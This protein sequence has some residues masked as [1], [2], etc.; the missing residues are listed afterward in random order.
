MKYKTLIS[1][2][3]FAILLF[4]ASGVFAQ[5]DNDPGVLPDGSLNP[6]YTSQFPESNTQIITLGTDTKD[7]DA[8]GTQ[9]IGCQAVSLDASVDILAGY[10]NGP[11]ARA[12]ATSAVRDYNTGNPCDLPSVG[13]RARLW[14]WSVWKGDTGMITYYNSADSVATTNGNEYAIGECETFLPDNDGLLARGNHE[15]GT[16]YS[17]NT[18]TTEKTC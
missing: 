14:K 4:T 18:D 3:V 8:I 2:S 16:L 1:A 12:S 6:G 7:L 11:Y 15:F 9:S 17:T 5:N 13:A 10:R